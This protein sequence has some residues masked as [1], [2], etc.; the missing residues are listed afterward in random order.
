METAACCRWRKK[1]EGDLQLVQPGHDFLGPTHPTITQGK[2]K[3]DHGQVRSRLG[4]GKPRCHTTKQP[5]NQTTKPQTT[6]NQPQLTFRLDTL[7]PHVVDFT[8][9]D[10]SS[11]CGRINTV[12][13]DGNDD[14][15]AVLE[16][17]V[18]VE[19]D[20]TCLIG[21]SD[22]GKDYVDHLDEHAVFLGVTGV[23]DDGWGSVG[24]S[25]GF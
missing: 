17:V 1:T 9:K 19:T 16:E 20:D 14:S 2:R 8:S 7:L 15:A 13:F 22:I 12:G 6:N 21:L 3:H 24:R 23:F 25:S 5:N 11:R 18:C 4:I 10:L